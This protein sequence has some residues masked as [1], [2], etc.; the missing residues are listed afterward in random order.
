MRWRAQQRGLT[1]SR[2]SR[3]ARLGVRPYGV[4]FVATLLATLLTAACHQVG[5]GDVEF[6]WFFISIALA[7][8]YGTAPG[9]FAGVLAGAITNF[10]FIPPLF[11]LQIEVDDVLRTAVYVTVSLM[12]GKLV[13]AR[14][15]AEAEVQDREGLLSYVAHELR[16]PLGAISSWAELIRRGTIPPER[17][18]HA[19]EVILRNGQI[20]GRITGDLLDLSR[21]ALGGLSLR[22]E[23]ID[24]AQMVSDCVASVRETAL[25][26]GV[27]LEEALRPVGHLLAD[28]ERLSQV[29]G[30]VLNNAIRF[31]PPGGEV[32]VRLR[33]E[34]RHAVLTVTDTGAG[35]PAE[36]LP[37][38]F[39]PGMRHAGSEGFGLGLTIAKDIVEHH[40]GTI[41]AQS[42]GQGRGASFP[43]VLPVV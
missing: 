30:N 37:R 40:G 29:V 20:L 19:A 16:T 41:S 43:I 24:P 23:P 6:A 33:E 14:Q 17:L 1:F 28:R 3:A 15:R 18:P 38:I 31:T 32:R 34:G 27:A 25:Q 42:D 13:R 35:I 2:A 5:L 11:D 8:S 36:L 9:V 12:I 21:I 26:K 10:L 7:S 39:E 4:A 22:R